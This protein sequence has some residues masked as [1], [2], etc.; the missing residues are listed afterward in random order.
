MRRINDDGK[1]VESTK[2]V[3]LRL[4][5][6]P[7]THIRRVRSVFN[8]Q[9]VIFESFVVP[10]VYVI[11]SDGRHLSFYISRARE[12]KRRVVAVEGLR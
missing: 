8:L 7:R 4:S 11:T 6:H 2:P 3:F 1:P 5:N 9:P 10:R 12:D